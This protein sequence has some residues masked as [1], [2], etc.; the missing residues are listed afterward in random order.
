[1]TY[2]FNLVLTV[3]LLFSLSWNQHV[4][5]EASSS[6]DYELEE[7]IRSCHYRLINS[8]TNRHLPNAV[9][10][11]YVAVFSFISPQNHTLKGSFCKLIPSTP[12]YL[13]HNVLRI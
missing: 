8:N 13:L 12:L 10:P 1:M 3:G 11:K 9:F 2:F 4:V 7:Y 5:A 6:H